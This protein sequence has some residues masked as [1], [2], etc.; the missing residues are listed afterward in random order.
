ML[1]LYYVISELY[2]YNIMI[3]CQY[4][5]HLNW[6]QKGMRT[7]LLFIKL[8]ATS[9]KPESRITWVRSDEVYEL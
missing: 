7:R 4:F 9:N 6:L 5:A 2:R 1:R 8:M 3:S